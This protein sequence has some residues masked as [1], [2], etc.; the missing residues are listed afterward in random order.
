VTYTFDCP[1]CSGNPG[2]YSSCNPPTPTP[3]TYMPFMFVSEESIEW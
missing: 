2:P 1:D 3:T